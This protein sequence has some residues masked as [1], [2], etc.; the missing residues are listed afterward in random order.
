MKC[1]KWA[2]QLSMG[3][4]D[5]DRIRKNFRENSKEAVVD[6]MARARIEQIDGTLPEPSVI[7][8]AQY[9][10]HWSEAIKGTI[11]ESSV[12]AYA[13]TLNKHVSTK[14]VGA[15]KLQELEPH[16][17]ERAMSVV[18]KLAAR[19]NAIRALSLCLEHAVLQN[20][21]SRNPCDKILR[22]K[23]IPK[24]IKPLGRDDAAKFLKAVAGDPLEALYTLAVG[25]GARMSELLAL[26]WSDID[27]KARVMSIRRTLRT[28]GG[29]TFPVP[30]KT[31]AGNRQINLDRRS[32]AALQAQRARGLK[33]G[34]AGHPWVFCKPGGEF[35]GRRDVFRAFKAILKAAKLPDIR[36]HDLRH[37][38]ATLL[39]LAGEHPKVVSERLGHSSIKVTLD[40]YSHVLP[41][42]QGSAVDR[43]DRLFG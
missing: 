11:G 1:G 40:V 18:T 39:L 3:G 41:T 5:K 15:V 2:G 35:L 16:H 8:L 14:P 9:V 21:I 23:V 34:A 42:M 10:A 25:T 29:R 13:K 22:P 17:I 33:I 24:E 4:S 30:P 12:D 32:V 36:F 26:K 43:Y 38:H 7:T 28:S 31:K 19:W 20:L 6:A 37:T 27:L